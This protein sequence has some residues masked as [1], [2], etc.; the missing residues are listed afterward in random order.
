MQVESVSLDEVTPEEIRAN[1]PDVVLLAG[2]PDPRSVA[3]VRDLRGDAE[4]PGIMFFAQ[5]G[6]SAELCLAD[7]YVPVGCTPAELVLRVEVLVAR[8]AL[9]SGAKSLRAGRIWM[10]RDTWQAQVDGRPVLL[11]VTEFELLHLLASNPGQVVAKRTILD[12]V[13]EHGFEGSTNVVETYVS[14]LRLKLSDTR[15]SI[16]K[17]VRGIGY[18][19]PVADV[20]AGPA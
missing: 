20:P 3:V 19:L 11:T 1:R 6:R 8:R 13:W 10:E 12:R 9:S 18:V 14:R 5:G 4:R 16:I 15:H 7:D 2:R 17:T